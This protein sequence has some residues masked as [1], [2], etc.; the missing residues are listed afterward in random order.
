[1]VK[2]A[3]SDRELLDTLRTEEQL[4]APSLPVADRSRLEPIS[5]VIATRDRPATLARTLPLLLGLEY[6]DARFIVVDNAPPNDETQH[7]VDTLRVR[8]PNLAY[9]REVAPGLSRARNKGL[10]CATTPLVVFADD[11]I[12]PEPDYLMF[13]GGSFVGRPDVWC[14]SGL[15]LPTSLDSPA[16]VLFEE[17]GGFVA[18][19]DRREFRREM[20]PAPSRLF[21]FTPGMLGTGGSLAFRTNRLRALGGFDPVL[22][23]GTPS[24][25]GEDLDITMRVIRAGGTIVCEPRAVVWHEHYRSDEALRKQVRNYGAGLTAAFTKLM[26]SPTTGVGVLRRLPAGL[27][28]LLAPNSAKNARRGREFPRELVFREL[29][30]VAFGWQSYLKSRANGGHFATDSEDAWVE[31]VPAL[32]ARRGLD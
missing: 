4:S 2:G 9:V 3:P 6:P 13:L 22:G 27:T 18:G 31:P 7:V 25:G 17:F 20:S 30:G 29:T 11:D 28:L 1:M 32:P 24:L 19:V 15:V 23:A 8:H 14:T 21:P 16:Q 5:V 12:E 10:D 26:L